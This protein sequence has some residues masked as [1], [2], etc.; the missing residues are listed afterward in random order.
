M[1]F[2]YF[3]E[4]KMLPF[5]IF[6]LVVGWGL[7]ALLAW[8]AYKVRTK[9]TASVWILAGC[10]FVLG[11]FPFVG[12]LFDSA[13]W[14]AIGVSLPLG[15]LLTFLS[16]D[17]F[18]KYKWCTDLVEAQVKDLAPIYRHRGVAGYVPV[19]SYHYRGESYEGQSFLPHSKRNLQHLFSKGDRCEIFVDPRCPE[20]CVDKKRERPRLHLLLMFFAICFFAFSIFLI[21]MPAESIAI[22]A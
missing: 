20:C 11:T 3:L 19:F 13:K 7:V 9:R 16:I 8:G 12:Y 14:F 21:C 22:R 18:L 1:S 10:F 15:L 6:F 2:Y 4:G 17:G 5:V